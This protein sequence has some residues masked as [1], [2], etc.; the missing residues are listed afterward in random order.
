MIRHS[1]I[2]PSVNTAE[3]QTEEISMPSGTQVLVRTA[4]S[5]VSPG[6]ERAN[7][8]GD[9]S[10]AGGKSPQV[11]FP[12][13]LGYSSAGTVVAI[14]DEVTDVASGDRVVVFWGK[15]TDLNLVDRSRVVPIPDGI[16]FREAAT[17]FI[18]TF[19]MAAIRKTRLEA[20]ESCLVMG[21]G[22]LGQFAVRIARAAGAV[23]VIAVDPV[24]ARRNDAMKGGADFALDPFAPDFAETVKELSHG[25]VNVAIEVTGQGAG[26]NEALDCMARFGRVALLGCTRNKDFT[27]DYYRKVH[28]PG[29]T[30]IGAHTM[31][32]PE[33]ESSPGAFTHTDDIL[34][35][36]RLTA[37]G[38]IDLK[39]M[40]SEVY[41]PAECGAVYDRLIH[42]PA[43]PMTVQFD[44][45]KTETEVDEK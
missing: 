40:L 15:H 25:G 19:P 20:G 12:R 28:F 8:T 16:S 14:G 2:F 3:L 10:V 39:S 34:A 21:L 30:L 33:F 4:Y 1:I 5:T 37:G 9:P 38:R 45:S 43:F 11:K 26:L 13:R 36:L 41:D 23:P 42:D 35:L 44:W 17:V 24:E 22:L 29:I 31:A 27:V 7:I 32:R 6:T 18:A